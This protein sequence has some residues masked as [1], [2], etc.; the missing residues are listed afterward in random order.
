[1]AWLWKRMHPNYS[2]NDLY[3]NYFLAIINNS[4]FLVKIFWKIYWTINWII[5]WFIYNITTWKKLK[6][7]RSSVW[8]YAFYEISNKHVWWN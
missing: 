5:S 7:L 8:I 1:M 4:K 6:N 2:K 3:R